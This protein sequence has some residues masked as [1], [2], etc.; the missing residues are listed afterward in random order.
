[1]YFPKTW[2]LKSRICVSFILVNFLPSKEP[3]TWQ[4]YSTNLISMKYIFIWMWRFFLSNSYLVW[5]FPWNLPGSWYNYYV[6]ETEQVQNKQTN[7]PTKNKQ[8]K[9]LCEG[10]WSN[11]WETHSPQWG[12]PHVLFKGSNKS[13]I[14]KITCKIR[15]RS[16]Y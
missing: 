4:S 5:N 14:S 16:K 3:S 12:R 2:P 13:H 1:M 7:N 15:D 10:P 6:L 8:T 11:P 9:N